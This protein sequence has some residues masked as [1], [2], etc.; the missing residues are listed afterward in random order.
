MEQANLFNDLDHD[1][2]VA[3]LNHIEY[4][5]IISL[6]YTVDARHQVAILRHLSHNLVVDFSRKD[7]LHTIHEIRV[8]VKQLPILQARQLQINAMCDEFKRNNPQ[9]IHR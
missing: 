9:I 8:F 3:L 2:F 4:E 6:Y 1:L 7:N 5:D